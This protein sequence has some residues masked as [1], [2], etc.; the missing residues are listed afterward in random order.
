MDYVPQFN[1]NAAPPTKINKK[2]KLLPGENK[3][4]KYFSGKASFV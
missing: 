4:R 2:S 3:D 1:K